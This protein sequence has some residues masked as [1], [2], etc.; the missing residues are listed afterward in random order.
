MS[1]D[2]PSDDELTALLHSADV[3]RH[4][5]TGAVDTAGLAVQYRIEPGDREWWWS[6]RDG[7]PSTGIGRI[8]DADVVVTCDLATARGLLDGT[9]EVSRAFLLGRLK[10]DGE[11]GAALPL[12][13][14]HRPA[15]TPPGRRG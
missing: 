5:A 3:Q 2:L 14:A 1:V 15:P 12:A 4:L 6:T 11:L 10:I 13:A 7:E 9:L 8:D